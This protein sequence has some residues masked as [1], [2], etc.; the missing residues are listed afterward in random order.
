[1]TGSGIIKERVKNSTKVY[2]LPLGKKNSCII[3]NSYA[4]KMH[5]VL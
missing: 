3:Y 4:F 1:M 5:F 2:F